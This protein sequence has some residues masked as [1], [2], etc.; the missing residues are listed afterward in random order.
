MILQYWRE[1]GLIVDDRNRPIAQLRDDSGLSPAERDYYGKLFAS[2]PY[3]QEFANVEQDRLLREAHAAA[4]C[5][6]GIEE[7]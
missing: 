3:L 6:D 4:Q 7:E 5:D 2:A 1:F